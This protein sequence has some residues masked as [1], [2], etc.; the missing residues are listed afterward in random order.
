MDSDI[1]FMWNPFLFLFDMNSAGKQVKEWETENFA[2]HFNSIV[3][4]MKM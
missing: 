2:N 4:I 1:V 3:F